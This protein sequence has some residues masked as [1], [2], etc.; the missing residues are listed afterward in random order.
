MQCYFDQSL[1]F[2]EEK[3][4]KPPFLEGFLRLWVTDPAIS[5][6]TPG[7]SNQFILASMQHNQ[8]IILPLLPVPA[9]SSQ[10]EKKSPAELRHSVLY[11]PNLSARA[12]R[13]TP[14]CRDASRMEFNELKDGTSFNFGAITDSP[15]DSML[16]HPAHFLVYLLRIQSASAMAL[17]IIR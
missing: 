13:M 4:L 1:I 5:P 7:H 3:K 8:T 6:H 12:N 14:S 2:R 15:P 10:T 17:C 11:C 9:F 16:P